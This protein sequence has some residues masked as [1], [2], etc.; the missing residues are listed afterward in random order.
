MEERAAARILA[1]DAHFEPLREERS[2]R[3]RFREAPIERQLARGHLLAILHD[4][5][6]LP[7]QREVAREARERLR[8]LAQLLDLEPR[9]HDL[10]PIDLLVLG[11]VDRVLVA[12]H[13]ERLLRLRLAFI[14]LA[15]V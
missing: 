11:P 12:D 10:G 13:A 2:V 6:A 3:E 8:E 7:M 9:R 1:G 15:A 5:R 14:H 4:L